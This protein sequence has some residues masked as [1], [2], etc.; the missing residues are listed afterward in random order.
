MYL[1]RVT[2]DIAWQVLLY[3]LPGPTGL[4]FSQNFYNF[5]LD[6]IIPRSWM[7][8]VYQ[9]QWQLLLRMDQVPSQHLSSGGHLPCFLKDAS[10]LTPKF[11][12][13]WSL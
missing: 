12:R 13:I 3:Q 5:F 7:Y 4:L 1:M 9:T 11:C 10:K 8:P 2:G 6:R